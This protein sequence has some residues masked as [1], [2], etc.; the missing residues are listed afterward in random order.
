[1]APQSENKLEKRSISGFEKYLSLWVILAMSVGT[2]TGTLFPA[3]SHWLDRL[4][5][6]EISLPVAVCLFFMMFPIM[7]KIDFTRIK[8][9][10]R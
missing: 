2:V 4:S 1:M 7:V 6:A 5:Y 8:A 3:V 10:L 9:A